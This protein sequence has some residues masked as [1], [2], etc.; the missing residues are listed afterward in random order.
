ME[1]KK[2][3]LGKT[4]VQY[5]INENKEVSMLLV[6]EAVLSEEKAPWD[7]EE[8]P[9]DPRARDKR[10]WKMGQLAH[11]HASRY[12]RDNNCMSMKYGTGD[13]LFFDGQEIKKEGIKTEIITKLVSE[14]GYVIMHTLRHFENR[15]GFEINTEFINNSG[16][17]VELEMLTS[18]ALDNLS[19][20]QEGDGPEKY[21]L[22]RF[23]GGWS[24]EGKHTK[25]PLEELALE[26]SWAAFFAQ[27]EKF[28]SLGSYPVERFF[29]AALVEDSEYGVFWGAQ[30]AHNASWQMELTRY[31][32]TLSFT[33]GI[34]D[35]EFG[36]WKKTLENGESF[37]APV[38]YVAAVHGDVYDVCAALTDMHKNA[39]EAYGEKGIPTSFNEFCATWGLP[40]QEKMLNFCDNLKDYGVKY[41]VIDAGWCKA[42]CEQ[43][44]NGEWNVDKTIFPDM[45]AM[46]A[47]IREAGMVPGIWFEFEATT[48]GSKM[49]LG[50]YDE[51]HLQKHGRTVQ[52]GG[53]R[54]Y[55]DLRRDDVREYLH[56]KVSKFLKENDF[57]YIKVDYNANAGAY[58]D[59]AESGAEA[60]R[61]HLQAVRKFFIEMREKNPGLIIENCAS[62]GHR[63]EPSMMGISAI[64]SFSD[65]HE[66]VEIPYIAANLHMLMLP[67]QELI[68]AVLHDDDSE[69]R[70]V[71]SLAAT[72]LGRVCLSGRVD[73]LN[74]RQK[75]ILKEAMVFYAKLE[76]IILNGNTKI[77]GNR[78]KS[79]RH[80][81]GTQVVVR[82]TED[83]MLV[84]CHAF[85]TPGE[86]IQIDIPEGFSV[87][88]SFYGNNIEVSGG[89]IIVKKMKDF[90]AG[91]VLLKKA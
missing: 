82:S 76:N 60:L 1:I 39:Q 35:R 75:Q 78:G 30:L 26:R 17:P 20:M 61:E 89:K 31:G 81:K 38:A 36:G 74:E 62:G 27:T 59:G 5:L 18:F 68:W 41:V 77:Y 53:I 49:F 40:T 6:P 37:V 22:H 54:S 70:E 21:F 23:Y 85:E 86:E 29:P 32:D 91:A 50:E 47:K 3:L 71:Y 72:F 19:P 4:E 58:V 65:A 14:D 8:A 64:S 69:E 25:V 57:G 67:A 10:V 56:E 87:A 11:F 46:N 55:W 7:V 33:G 12:E 88:D 51:M 79:L 84:V 90:T 73:K 83:E 15:R 80:P 24:L 63:L 13:K 45:K 28:G 2:Y 48:K 43:D 34:A 9:F 52:T 42:G 66:C 16:E 44:G